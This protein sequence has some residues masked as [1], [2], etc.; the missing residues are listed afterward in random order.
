M[1]PFKVTVYGNAKPAGSKRAF[2]RGG[3]A[4][5]TDANPNSRTWK[6]NVGQ[7]VGEA[8]GDRPMLTGPVAVRFT[9]FVARPK[10]HTGARGLKPSAPEYPAKRPD[11]LKLA[12][13]VEDAMTGIVYQD[14]SLIV[15]ELL[16][17]EYGTPERCEIFVSAMP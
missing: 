16:I 11:L 9:F 5:I 17:K 3:K 8:W 15:R 1:A 7:V 12:R 10:S 6:N 14:D 4:S 2:I 13:G